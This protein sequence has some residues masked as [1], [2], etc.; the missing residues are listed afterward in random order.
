VSVS[1][2]SIPRSP[3]IRVRR[4][5][6]GVSQST[7]QLN[8]TREARPSRGEH[9]VLVGAAHPVRGLGGDGLD[10]RPAEPAHEVEVVGGQVLDDP[11]VADPVRERPDALGGDEEQL[12]ERGQAA[13]QLE[14]RGVEP[15]DVADRGAHAGGV[16][17]AMRSRASVA[18]AARGFS[19]RTC[20]PAAASCSTAAT[21]SSVGT[22]TTAKSGRARASRASTVGNSRSGRGRRRAV[23]AGSTAPANVTLALDCRM[24]AW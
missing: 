20:T 16:D 8:V 2:T 24:R 4:R 7:W 5:L 12:A 13:A 18:V 19:T 15:L 6:V 9:E 17:P 3:R 1:A 14:Q 11:D 23:A 22:A 21:C 10:R